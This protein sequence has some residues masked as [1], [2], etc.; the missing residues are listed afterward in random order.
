MKASQ[1]TLLPQPESGQQADTSVLE[2]STD[3]SAETASSSQQEQEPG[4]GQ[5]SVSRPV[6][7]LPG[8]SSQPEVS[9]DKRTISQSG[10]DTAEETLRQVV[11]ESGDVTLA[12][13]TITGNLFI[14]ESAEGQVRLEN[15]TVEGGIYVYGA[16]LVELRDVHT[17]LLRLQRDNLLV[18]AVAQGTT[19]IEKTLVMC[20]ATLR[21]RNLGDSP[22]FAAVQVESGG[23]LIKNNI[24]LLSVR[25]DSLVVNFNS[26]ISLSTNTYIQQVDANAK[27]YLGGIGE[28]ADLVVRNDYVQ[29]TTPPE[30]ITVKRGYE[31]PV[32]VEPVYEA[33]E[34]GEAQEQMET[35]VAS[36]KLDTPEDIELYEENGFLTVHFTQVSVNDGYSVALYVDGKQ[37]KVVFTDI[38]ENSI[39]LGDIDLYRG[40]RCYVKVKALGSLE[41]NTVDSEYGK[42]RRYL[43]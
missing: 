8:S 33:D 34:N 20:N 1:K 15:L 29:Y 3:T 6:I 24:S 37:D 25:L 30:N 35:D 32:Q 36:V 41:D 17:P 27:L 2:S 10:S 22:G 19:Q 21:E 11:I 23:V 13:K 39:S 42:S 5:S 43:F 40:A 28:V 26:R 14:M 7:S 4:S 16:D 38:D 12:N 31:E 18:T 9:S